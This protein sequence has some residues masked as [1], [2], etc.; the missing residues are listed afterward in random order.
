MPWAILASFLCWHSWAEKKQKIFSTSALS[1]F[2]L[3]IF[4]CGQWR[5]QQ[6]VAA[7]QPTDAMGYSN[8]FFVLAFLGQEKIGSASVL[9]GFFL[10]IFRCGQWRPRQVVAAARPTDT[11]D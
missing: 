11:M 6:V 5:P 1:G 9:A 3:K 10:K 4:G 8:L 7:T 2:P